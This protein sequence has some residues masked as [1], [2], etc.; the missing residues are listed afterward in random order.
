L[1]TSEL[2]LSGGSS[3]NPAGL[4]N[5]G[6]LEVT[7]QNLLSGAADIV[8]AT[9]VKTLILTAGAIDSA[10]SLTIGGEETAAEVANNANVLA[11]IATFCEA[12]DIKIE[13]DAVLTDPTTY[14]T[15]PNAINASVDMWA[16][17]AASVGLPIA[18]VE[19]VQEIGTDQSPSMFASF[20]TIE[21]NAVRTLIADYASSSY[22]MTAA[23]LAVGDM[24]GA[25]ASMATLPLWWNA[26]NA[27]ARADGVST[28]SY[29]TADTGWFAPWIGPLSVPNWQAYL[30]AASALA[31][32]NH[33]AL[34]VVV[35]GAETDASANQF[36]Q[37]TEQNA[38]DLAMLQA[39]G[40][41]VVSSIMIQSWDALPVGVGMISSP[42]S[43]PN[44]AAEIEAVYPFYTDGLISAQG[45]LTFESPG[46]VI[47]NVGTV[48]SIVPLSVQWDASDV[49]AGNRLGMVIIDQTGVLTATRYGSGNV[50]NPANNILILNG[51]SAD[52]AAELTSVTL[53]EPN[54]GPDTIDVETYG[55]AGRLSDNQISVFATASPGLSAESVNSTSNSQGWLSA[56]AI[57]NNGTVV[58]SE[59]LQWSTTG[60]LAGTITGTTTPG[61]SAFLNIVSIHEPLAEYGVENVSSIALGT[62]TDQVLDIYD[63]AVDNG[64]FPANG[65]ANNPGVNNVAFAPLANWLPGSFNPDTE[66]TPLIVQS[67]TNAFDPVNGQLEASVDI[68]APDPLTVVDLTGTYP[69]TFAT[70]FNNGGSQATEFNTGNN[71]AW[72]QG[73]GSQFSSVISTYDSAGQ[74][75][76]RF[77]QGGASDPL[78]T[79]DDVLD[80]NT[81]QLWE[82]FLSTT[83]PPVTPGTTNYA[84]T[85]NPYQAGFDTGPLYVTE[86]NTGDNPNWDLDDWGST[87]SSDTEVWTDYMILEN[88]AGFAVN[89]PGQ[90]SGALNAYPYE[91]VNG[92]AL[93]LM[94]LP[95]TINV[96]LNTLGTVTIA[97]QTMISGLGGLSEIDAAGAT[98][99]V[100][101]TGLIAGSSSLIGGDNTST[102]NGYGN[103]TIIAGAGLTTINTGSGGSTVL[104]SNAAGSATLS[105]NNNVVTGVAGSTIRITGTGETVDG[106]NMTA[107]VGSSSSITV[108]GSNDMID[109]IGPGITLHA[110][111]NNSV[112]VSDTVADVAANLNTLETWA[113]SGELVSITLTGGGSPTLTLTAEELTAD[114]AA[115]ACIDS[116]YT[117]SVASNTANLAT[118][119]TSD[120]TGDGTSDILFR[121]NATGDTGYFAPPS[122]GGQDTWVGL[123]ASSTA[124]SVAGIG[125]FTGAG[126]SDI[127]FRDNATGDTGYLAMP[128]GGG[129]GSWHDLGASS[130]AYSIVGDGDFTGDGI[131]DL[132]YRNG[133]TGD[134]GVFL[135]SVG[136][137]D[138]WQGLGAPSL[139]YSVVGVGDFTGNGKSDILFR[140]NGTGDTGYYEVPSAGNQ[141]TWVG[142]GASSTAYSVAGVGDFTGTGTSDILFR[143]NATGDTGYLAMPKGG[144]QGTWVDL[145]ISSTAFSVVGVGDFA[146]NGISDILFRDIATG[147]TGY[148]TLP[149]GGGQGTWHE[150]G[151]PSTAYAIISSPVFG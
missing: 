40:S 64:A 37:Q 36:V 92:S 43:S 126:T 105:G 96:N 72:Q 68:L 3:G 30:E 57:L 42:T 100:T 67:T 15:G 4:S 66:L 131:A 115:L 11:Q 148:L 73:W 38:A 86:F 14:G 128:P 99:A 24:E 139:L 7:Y 141:G 18:A 98:G 127:L 77:F 48:K 142:L 109:V 55:I 119:P 124:Y 33:L 138:T 51:D 9:R 44:E 88:F 147:D 103:D 120:F 47:L 19:D 54:A 8:S 135:L 106:S 122:G 130:T 87:I 27:A 62:A 13:V 45:S 74:L 102:I 97:S 10:S 125:D 84:T 81:G 50:S 20:A 70:A 25:P 116:P 56:S 69:D 133:T 60:T 71:V 58:T 143:D 34:D 146:G 137:T 90:Y 112:F 49:L 79:I 121:D 39:T 93:D 75:V 23:N 16:K 53:M 6:Q 101:I 2:M 59:T 80:P 140:N 31:A 95:G 78:F 22:T 85:N 113:A 89:F 149:A 108:N 61:Q 65:Y 21:A 129:Q 94:Y 17:V 82:E 132:L 150:L 118:A 35:Q 136:G 83:P 117:V 151:S 104:L 91:F 41:I 28:F 1:S 63:L 123:G 114:A 12:N 107:M 46:Q 144:G 110:S 5:P 145:G 26:Y 134:M 111:D 29:T 32:A 76:E 52:L